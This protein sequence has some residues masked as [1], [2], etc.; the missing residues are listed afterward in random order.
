MGGIFSAPSPPPLPKPP[1]VDTQGEQEQAR[2]DALERRRRGRAG[3]ILTSDRG[4]VHLAAKQHG[5]K[6]LLGE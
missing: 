6:D 2:L 3:T 4:L 5:K 1:T